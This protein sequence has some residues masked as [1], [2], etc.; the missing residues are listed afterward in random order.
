MSKWA[1][2]DGALL[3]LIVAES[4]KVR[5]ALQKSVDVQQIAHQWATSHPEGSSATPQEAR[6]WASLN[7]SPKTS[8]V[9]DALLGVYAN[10]AELGKDVAVHM[11]QMMVANKA[12]SISVNWDNWK[13]GNHPAENLVRPKGGMARLLA[14]T[15]TTIK[16]ISKTTLDRIGTKLADGLKAGFSDTKIAESLAGVIEDPS[17]ALAI[18]H[19]EMNRAFNA[20]SIDYYKDSGLEKIEW[21]TSDPCDICAD[22]DGEVVTIGEEFPSGDTEPPVH[23]NCNCRVIPY[24]DLEG[25]DS[26]STDAAA[27]DVASEEA[28]SQAS[29][30]LSTAQSVEPQVSGMFS[31]LVAGFVDEGKAVRM[32]GLENKLKSQA[33][34]ARKIDQRA[35]DLGGNHAEAAS[36]ISDALRYTM[37]ANPSA[38]AD[39]VKATEEKFQA[40]GYQTNLKNY[41]IGASPYKGVNLALTD[42][43]GM[44][45]ELQFHTPQSLKVKEHANHVLYERQRVLAP[46]SKESQDLTNQMIRNSSAIATPRGIDRLGKMVAGL[47]RK[48]L[49]W[50]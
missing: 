40:L 3:R 33:S 6:E 50:A 27:E 31:G 15:D 13:P 44:K 46:D 7:I 1:S 11:V 24:I 26:F 39:V 22:N 5:E 21:D 36:T 38:Y 43:S 29:S 32:V 16:G 10:G 30:L 17:R 20:R 9:K 34:L 37:L 4:A 41:W 35:A 12:P 23:T 45:I 14:K 2:I 42:P 25:L 18:A 48:A 28:T 8:A 49:T 19:T 47:M